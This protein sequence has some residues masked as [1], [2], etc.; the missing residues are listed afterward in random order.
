MDQKHFTT[1]THGLQ[2]PFE[3]KVSGSYTHL[4]MLKL[5]ATYTCTLSQGNAAF[6]IRFRYS[7]ERFDLQYMSIFICPLRSAM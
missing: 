2:S 6:G 7:E 3:F 1:L 5:G 4:H